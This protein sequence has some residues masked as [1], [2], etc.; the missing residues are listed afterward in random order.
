MQ[1]RYSG[2]SALL[3]AALLL[4][5]VSPPARAQPSGLAPSA[6]F[7]AVTDNG[8]GVPP[9][10]Q[11][12]AGPDHL[13]TM[14]NTRFAAQL[15]NGTVVQI[16]TPA[17][18][19]ASVSQKDLLFDPRVMYDSLSNRWY[20]VMATAG[21]TAEPAILLAVSNGADPTQGWTFQSIPADPHGGAAAEFPLL[22]ASS[23]WI[24]V[25]SNLISA[26]GESGGIAVWAIEK[27]ALLSGTLSVSRFVLPDALSPVAPVVTFDSDQPDEL[28]V[29]QWSENNAGKGQLELLRVTDVSGVVSL[30]TVGTVSAP[31]TWIAHPN[32]F[33]M[34]PQSGTPRR[35]TAS[36]DDVASACLRHGVIWA[37]QTAT[38]PEKTGPSQAT[39]PIHSVVQWWRMTAEGALLG[40]GRIED[41]SGQT[42]LAYPSV[43]VNARDQVVIGYSIFSPEIFAS[44]GYSLRRSGGCD[45]DLSRI[46]TLQPGLGVYVK[47]DSTGLNRWGDLS[48]TVVDPGDDLSIWTIQEYAAAPFEG[49]SRWGT[50][51]GGFAPAASGH[52]GACVSPVETGPPAP[53][54]TR[55]ETGPR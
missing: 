34:L 18:F 24:C 37:A 23:R 31:A 54:R 44:A 33:D 40:F 28:L 8:G 16:W 10:P 38:I 1:P 9:D 55:I 50:W 11:G 13:L 15:K 42:W 29:E 26:S 41:A 27:E 39:V 49:A 14:T 36:Q 47:P 32:P 48:E 17:Q 30:R 21:A 5:L 51:W 45:A 43:A 6:G 2:F 20:A 22:G 25:T 46:H 3:P 19:W 52:E 12:A 7:A 53:V 4:V 35:I